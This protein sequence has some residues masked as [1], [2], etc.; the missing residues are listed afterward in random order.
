MSA[1]IPYLF[2][3]GT[4]AEALTFYRSV[5]GGELT[6]H[7]YAEFDRADG[8]GD[9]IA[10]GVLTGPVALHAS[11]A[12]ADEDAVHLVG[13]AFALLGAA[14]PVVLEEWFRALS[15][16]GRVL[17]PLQQRT[18]GAHDGQ[19]VDRYGIRWLIGYEVG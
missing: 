4:A 2:L 10:H 9:A 14:E 12:G 15:A 19:V 18:W 16:E 11:D 6:L 3:P 13:A 1:P 5:F 17:D 8:P 7:T